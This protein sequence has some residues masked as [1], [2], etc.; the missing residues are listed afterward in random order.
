MT[1]QSR[2]YSRNFGLPRRFVPRN[3]DGDVNRA[4]SHLSK[5]PKR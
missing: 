5:K 4:I 1:R 2:V 3:D